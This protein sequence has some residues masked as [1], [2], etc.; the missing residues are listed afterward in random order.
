[1]LPFSMLCSLAYSSFSHSLVNSL[2]PAGWARFHRIYLWTWKIST[3][4]D[5]ACPV[6]VATTDHD[7]LYL[8]L[9]LNTRQPLSSA[10]HAWASDYTPAPAD[11]FPLPANSSEELALTLQSSNK[12]RISYVIFYNAWMKSLP[13]AKLSSCRL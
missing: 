7:M 13:K 9:S 6:F 11:C 2:T 10:A 12:W 5:F 8:L 1:M 3:A 4:H